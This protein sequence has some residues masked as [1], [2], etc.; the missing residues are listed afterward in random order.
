[1]ES[2]KRSAEDWPASTN[3][4]AATSEQIHLLSPEE[5]PNNLMLNCLG[6]S[7]EDIIEYIT[8]ETEKIKVFNALGKEWKDEVLCSIRKVIHRRCHDIMLNKVVTSRE[9]TTLL[10]YN[11]YPKEKGLDEEILGL[12][13]NSSNNSSTIYSHRIDESIE[14]CFR[15]IITDLKSYE[16]ENILHDKLPSVEAMEDKIDE[17]DK[18]LHNV[19]VERKDTEKGKGIEETSKVMDVNEQDRKKLDKYYKMI[20]KLIAPKIVDLLNRH[21]SEFQE[22]L[23]NYKEYLEEEATI[24]LQL[25]EEI[26]KSLKEENKQEIENYLSN[27]NYNYEERDSEKYDEDNSETDSMN[28]EMCLDN[29][30]VDREVISENDS[31]DS[32]MNSEN[33]NKNEENSENDNMNKD[34]SENNNM[35]EENSVIDNSRTEKERDKLVQSDANVNRP[36]LEYRVK[37]ISTPDMPTKELMLEFLNQF[38]TKT[39]KKHKT[40]K[41]LLIINL[42][43][44]EDYNNILKASGTIIGS[45]KL[46]ISSENK[47]NVNKN[48]A[49]NGSDDRSEVETVKEP[50]DKTNADRDKNDDIRKEVQGTTNEREG[51]S[52]IDATKQKVIVKQEPDELINDR[53]VKVKKEIDS[54][55]EIVEKE[56][57]INTSHVVNTDA[58]EFVAW[59]NASPF[60]PKEIAAFIKGY[61]PT[62]IKKHKKVPNVVL[63]TFKNRSDYE[64]FLVMD[65]HQ[66]NSGVMSINI[67]VMK[68]PRVEENHS[69]IAKVQSNLKE[70]DKAKDISNAQD[71]K[72]SIK[73]LDSQNAANTSN[74]MDEDELKPKVSNI[75]FIT[76]KTVTAINKEHEI[77]KVSNVNIQVLDKNNDINTCNRVKR[78]KNRYSGKNVSNTPLD[79]NSNVSVRN[80]PDDIII[81]IEDDI[82]EIKEE[83]SDKVEEDN[84]QVDL[85]NK[86]FKVEDDIVTVD[87]NSSEDSGDILR[88]MDIEQFDLTSDS[89]D[90]VEIICENDKEEYNGNLKDIVNKKITETFLKIGQRNKK[91]NFKFLNCKE[92]EVECEQT[93]DIETNENTKT[94]TKLIEKMFHNELNVLSESIFTMLN[95]DEEYVIIKSIVT[96]NTKSLCQSS[97]ENS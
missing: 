90:S 88:I 86:I 49:K 54:V 71:N 59:V 22:I 6:E 69:N 32:E 7:T 83:T 41:N 4:R 18:N 80:E 92:L 30:E 26:E 2:N 74:T 97:K 64:N 10:Y 36:D 85:N 50:N 12:L 81:K 25:R 67:T 56:V 52:E 21:R 82:V 78:N 47:S 96:D 37:L 79:K 65:G 62:A 34:N 39:I 75:K 8:K 87:D 14:K 35:N 70:N 55:E 76:V 60:F 84:A 29:D 51:N 16:D 58:S 95:E 53:I 13:L 94:E 31:E 46:L 38:N 42:N 5:A 48:N 9:D 19:D 66:I 40:I 1:M 57:N 68:D 73:V 89:N 43:T 11:T 44:E 3:K 23:K 91:T 27:K 93:Q 28:K 45:Q 63:V 77:D 61:N 15:K 33:D 72:I 20:D 17:V 24:K